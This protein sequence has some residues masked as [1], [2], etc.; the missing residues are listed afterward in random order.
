MEPPTT[1]ALVPPPVSISYEPASEPCGGSID[2][3]IHG[4]V[5]H[6][7]HKHAQ[8]TSLIELVITTIKAGNLSEAKKIIDSVQVCSSGIAAYANR[9]GPG[10]ADLDLILINKEIGDD[11]FT[12]A[13]L[14]EI[15]K[16]A[17]MKSLAD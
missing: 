2:R 8:G 13:T 4:R 16:N 3:D 15:Y 7:H 9:A 5:K 6:V 10:R 14:F 17:L 11:C 12:Y 1:Y